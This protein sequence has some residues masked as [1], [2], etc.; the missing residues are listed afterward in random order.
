[1]NDRSV[2]EK[3]GAREPRLREPADRKPRVPVEALPQ[4]VR[5]TLAGIAPEVDIAL[6]DPAAPLRRQVDLDSADWLEF[7]IRLAAA[8]GID[9]PDAVARRLTTIDEIV[10]WHGPQHP[11]AHRPEAPPA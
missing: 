6:L 11:E 10:A 7:L 5:D 4:L 2:P 3:P 9:I 8:T 1:V